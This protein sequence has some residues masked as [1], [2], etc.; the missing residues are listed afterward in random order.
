M[1]FFYYPILCLTLLGCSNNNPQQSEETNK[2]NADYIEDKTTTELQDSQSVNESQDNQN[3]GEE[4][5]RSIEIV[6]NHLKNPDTAK[7]RN[8][9][10]NCGEVNAMNSF[11]AYEGY[12]GF[13]I[14]E[15]EGKTYVNFSSST[16]NFNLFVRDFCK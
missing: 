14:W 9:K 11:G 4:E 3:L 8:V 7:F 5:L 16:N 1:K 2:V 13:V 6:K 12:N 15:A 10:N